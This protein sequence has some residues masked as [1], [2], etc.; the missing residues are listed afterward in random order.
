[1]ASKGYGG[2]V[3]S[4][5]DSQA[6]FRNYNGIKKQG[7]RIIMYVEHRTEGLTRF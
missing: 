2:R 1:M 4:A 3:D 6:P 5:T 7:T